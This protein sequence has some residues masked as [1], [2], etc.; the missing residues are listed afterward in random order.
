MPSAG[1]LISTHAD[2]VIGVN[3]RE[4]KRRQAPRARAALRSYAIAAVLVAVVVLSGCGHRTAGQV[5]AQADGQAEVPIVE[6]P[7][8]SGS[9]GLANLPVSAS[10]SSLL[11]PGYR[12]DSD[13]DTDPDRSLLLLD[14][15]N[16]V[17]VDITNHAEFGALGF[18]TDGD[19]VW[20]A[21]D[22]SLGVRDASTGATT[23]I[24]IPDTIDGTIST[25]PGSLQAVEEFISVTLGGADS[26][27]D[28]TILLSRAGSLHCA[29]PTGTEL[30][31]HAGF[32][33]SD[34]AR[35][36]VDPT[37]CAITGGLN[38]PTDQRLEALRVDG[39]SAYVA[40]AGPDTPGSAASEISLG[41]VRRFDVATGQQSAVGPSIPLEVPEMVVHGEEVWVLSGQELTRLDATTLAMIAVTPLPS[42]VV[43]CDGWPRL[44]P[45]A[46]R[47]FLLDE[48]TATL[49][50]LDPE[51][52]A[53]RSGWMLPSGGESDFEIT[54]IPTEEGIWMADFDQTQLP[55]LFDT[56]ELRFERP[57][58]NAPATTSILAWDF[59]VHPVPPPEGRPAPSTTAP[60]TTDRATGPTSPGVA[61]PE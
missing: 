7:P 44:V 1:A 52:G 49:Y 5:D 48:C 60:V 41:T 8:G 6:P 2:T 42:Q 16:E 57:P 30:T 20:A 18:T 40:L 35:T 10:T 37:T 32:L 9:D 61:P 13:D 27:S 11:V 34:D 31:S 21:G 17:V 15:A 29:G 19:A 59:A 26:P 43:E 45:Q 36:R 50:L 28:Q 33:W 4:G 53:P 54:E 3:E 56:A 51:T 39:T 47:V 12:Y 23:S 55:F 14:L 24:Q 38:L 46:D 22:R 25:S 58:V